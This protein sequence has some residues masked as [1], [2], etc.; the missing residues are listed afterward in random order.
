MDCVGQPSYM[1][2]NNGNNLIFSFKQLSFVRLLN[3]FACIWT[4]LY[5]A[6]VQDRVMMAPPSDN[7]S[8]KCTISVPMLYRYWAMAISRGTTMF[9]ITAIY[10]GFGFL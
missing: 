8:T 9:R 3:A 5:F 6:D 7:G 1:I 4:I 10:G 2:I